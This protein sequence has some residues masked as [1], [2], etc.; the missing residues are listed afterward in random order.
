MFD[1]ILAGRSVVSPPAN[2]SPDWLS[3]LSQYFHL[4]GRFAAHRRRHLGELPIV[5]TI[6]FWWEIPRASRIQR[7]KLCTSS[8]RLP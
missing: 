3:E 2:I 6:Y 4:S 7:K 1:Y 8:K 5:V